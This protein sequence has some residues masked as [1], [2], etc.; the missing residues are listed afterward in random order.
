MG[1]SS[2]VRHGQRFWLIVT[3]NLCHSNM[4]FL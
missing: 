1:D 3:I 2:E 4:E